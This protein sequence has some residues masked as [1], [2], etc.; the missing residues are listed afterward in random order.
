MLQRRSL[1]LWF[2]ATNLYQMI[3]GSNVC[4]C[5][6]TDMGHVV[7][8]HIISENYREEGNCREKAV[9]FRHG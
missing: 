5:V 7:G 3:I 8:C 9:P 6:V 2:P 4:H 1:E